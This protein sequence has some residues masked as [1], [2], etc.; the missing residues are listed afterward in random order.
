MGQHAILFFFP[1]QWSSG[2]AKCCGQ[3]NH[4]VAG[5][6]FNERSDPVTSLHALLE[7]A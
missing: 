5:L 4:R 7:M 3:C 1:L 2:L 6:M